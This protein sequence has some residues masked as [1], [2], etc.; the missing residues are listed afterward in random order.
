MGRGRFIV[1]LRPGISSLGLNSSSLRP[2]GSSLRLVASSLGLGSSS[3]SLVAW[4]TSS[5]WVASGHLGSLALF[6]AAADS[7]VSL[8]MLH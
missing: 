1:C 4:V 3:L 8:V 5:S 6:L 7:P 2:N